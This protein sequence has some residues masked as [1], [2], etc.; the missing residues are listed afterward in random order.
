M[1]HDNPYSERARYN[2]DGMDPDW[3]PPVDSRD[4]E[5][6]D[7]RAN[8][9]EATSR[10]AELESA[11]QRTVGQMQEDL[12]QLVDLRARVEKAERNER[13][14]LWLRR[15]EASGSITIES[16][17]PRPFNR[18]YN[19]SGEEADAAIDAALTAERAKEGT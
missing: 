14:Y 13:R 5:L 11:A 6:A 4:T 15:Q 18:H 17:G 1:S 10:V 9:R 12:Q 19:L 2:N 3:K 7:L 8:L 16:D